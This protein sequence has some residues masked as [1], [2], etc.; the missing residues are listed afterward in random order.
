L[1]Y[2]F[3]SLNGSENGWENA[4]Q[5]DYVERKLLRFTRDVFPYAKIDY[6]YV[7]KETA[8]AIPDLAAALGIISSKTV[9]R[10]MTDRNAWDETLHVG[11]SAMRNPEAG[12]M[13]NMIGGRAMVLAVSYPGYSED[14]IAEIVG[15]NLAHEMG[16]CY[17]ILHTP[18]TDG[19]YEDSSYPYGGAGL[20]GGWG[21]SMTTNEFYAEDGHAEDF[22]MPNPTDGIFT[23]SY[24]K[25]NIPLWDIMSYQGGRSLAMFCDYNAQK[26][27]PVD[28]HETM[29]VSPHIQNMP[30]A[31]RHPST[32]TLIFNQAAA[33]AVEE[34]WAAIAGAPAE[35]RALCAAELEGDA[36]FDVDAYIQGLI[37]SWKPLPRVIFTAVPKVPSPIVCR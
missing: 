13:T 24:P 21:Y 29:H 32:G 5:G 9:D 1:G 26:L 11:F 7:G 4:Y 6:K 36:A 3:E 19:R 10:P 23:S 2:D 34:T 17:Y 8:V 20:A 12:G 37:D 16:H 28:M 18:G 22:H 33:K 31:K 27:V 30:N 14:R 35:P 15:T 25:R